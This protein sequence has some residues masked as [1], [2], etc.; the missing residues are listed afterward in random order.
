[1]KKT[2]QQIVN[3]HGITLGTTLYS[4]FNVE[5][6]NYA[7][8]VN[9]F[10]CSKNL[11][12]TR[13]ICEQLVKTGYAVLS[14]D[15]TGL[16]SSK[17][18][19][20]NSHFSS[21]ISDI[22]DIYFF[23]EKNYKTPDLIIGHSLGGLAAIV[24]ASQLQEIKGVATIA[25]PA[26]LSHVAKHFSH[27]IE[28]AKTK[29]EVEIN[30]GGRPF[31]IDSNFVADFLGKDVLPKIKQLRKPIL[32]LH[33]PEDKI[34]EIE[35]AELLFSHAQFPKNFITLKNADHLLFNRKDAEYVGESIAN[36]SKHYIAEQEI[37]ADKKATDGN[38]V[39]AHLD[40]KHQ[41]FKTIIETKKHS[42]IVDES[43]KHG[44]EA[45]APAPYDYLLGALAAC[46]A[47]TIK[48]YAE[49]SNWELHDIT[50]HTRHKHNHTTDMQSGGFL[51]TITMRI[52]INGDLR[53]DQKERLLHIS[54]TC[55]V[56]KALK[57][58]INIK[59]ETI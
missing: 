26:S 25:A 30:I 43:G 59:T 19:F 51:E 6:K 36:W 5:V 44:G 50:V 18:E 53:C 12:S 45:V 21:N 46:T 52:N 57:N 54:S 16:G 13:L 39:V 10:T 38:E 14:F 7:I 42:Y 41:N 56:H 8:F 2:D 28:A 34:V 24:A 40:V 37:L 49:R 29:P 22:E 31:N 48:V 15:F 11:H 58:I 55:P 33:S 27:G 20:K 9:C 17:G 23:L 35:N 47:M 3:R 1:M 4:P 32:I